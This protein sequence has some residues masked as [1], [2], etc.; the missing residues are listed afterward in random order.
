MDPPRRAVGARFFLEASP[1]PSATI[2]LVRGVL[3]QASAVSLLLM[4]S[5]LVGWLQ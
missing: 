3:E 2:V 5:G 1:L 4:L